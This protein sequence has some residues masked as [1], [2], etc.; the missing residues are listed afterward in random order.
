MNLR[1]LAI[2][3]VARPAPVRV[4]VAPQRELALV[5]MAAPSINRAVQP[6]RVLALAVLPL[7][8]ALGKT[9]APSISLAARLVPVQELV[10]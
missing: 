7:G 2:S 1:A 4:P 10:V 6:G 5:K 9:A 3:Q 8:Q